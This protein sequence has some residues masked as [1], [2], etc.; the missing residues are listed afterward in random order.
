MSTVPKSELEI[1]R[2]T[3]VARTLFPLFREIADQRW[4]DRRALEL[5]RF[6]GR[7]LVRHGLESALEGY[8]SYPYRSSV[9]PNETAVHG[10]PS[11]RV[12]RRGDIF[13]VDVAAS[14]G[15]YVSDSAWTFLAPGASRRVSRLYTRSWRAFRGLLR[16]LT[17]GLSL[18]ELAGHASRIAEREGVR[19]VP[20]LLGHGVGRELHEP[21][22][23]AFVPTGTDAAREITL[24][25]GSILNI[26]PVYTDGS[27]EI[28]AL[29]DGWGFTTEDG[30]ST[31]H[32][33]LTVAI[34]E[35]GALVLQFDQAPVTEIPEDIPFGLLLE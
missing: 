19:I 14:S 33:E 29:D 2:L 34:T 27:G 30:S 4:I 8:R 22:V 20:S 25:A 10:L 9:S 5:D 17:A 6:V 18:E 7:Y 11:E 23:L 1:R 24:T 26:E 31:V 3:S 32:F 28:R 13:T 21:P 15:G 12:F 35:T 16:S